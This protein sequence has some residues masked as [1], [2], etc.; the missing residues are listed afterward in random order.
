METLIE[1]TNEATGMR[2]IV[3]ANSKA[4]YNVVLQD[5]DSGEYVPFVTT[6]P[7]FERAESEAAKVV[8]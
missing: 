6:Y 3:V 4:G 5:M 2:S 8:A 1:F 7:T